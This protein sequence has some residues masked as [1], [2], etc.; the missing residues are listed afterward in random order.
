[1]P[2]LRLAL[3]V[4]GLIVFAAALPAQE[5]PPSLE[6]LMSEADAAVAAQKTRI[7]ETVKRAL[8]DF[9]NKHKDEFE[10]KQQSA[11]VAELGPAAI[12]DLLAAFEI[13]KNERALRTIADLF[14][15]IDDRGCVAP[16]QRFAAGDQELRAAESVRALGSLASAEEAAALMKIVANASG[17]RVRQE[18]LV[19][20]ARLGHEPARPLWVSGLGDDDERIR[21]AA[22]SAFGFVGRPADVKLLEPLLEDDED[23]VALAA[24]ESLG[25]VAE[26]TR[27][28]RALALVH[29]AL[30]RDDPRFIKAVLDVVDR[31]KNSTSKTHLKR[32]VDDLGGEEPARKVKTGPALRKRAAI[33]LFR[34]LGVSY[35]RDALAEPL[36]K[37]IRAR[38]RRAAATW[39]RLSELYFEFGDWKSA[40]DAG[41]KGLKRNENYTQQI[42]IKGRIARSQA[43]LGKFAKAA[44]T[45]RDAFGA[46]PWPDLADDPAFQEMRQDRRYRKAFDRP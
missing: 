22:A 8:Q 32:L 23:I 46:A 9:R 6:S 41:E 44:K 11:R 3:L 38:P 12:P 29:G 37:Q 2:P 27:S 20:L 26:R 35:G 5:G 14:V 4:T 19:A 40:I 45:L 25:Q 33:I 28:T 13:E 34:R 42:E 15:E 21:A 36:K 16:L 31:L 1:M 17:V 10:I 39:N 30:E 43:Y 18:G 7:S 24:V